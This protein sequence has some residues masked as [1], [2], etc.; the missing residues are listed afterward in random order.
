MTTVEQTPAGPVRKG[1]LLRFTPHLGGTVTGSVLE[2]SPHGRNGRTT[3][4]LECGDA[5]RWCYL[6]QVI[7][8][9]EY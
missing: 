5:G 4:L 1:T 3:L 8:I 7:E 6:D 9:I 2:F